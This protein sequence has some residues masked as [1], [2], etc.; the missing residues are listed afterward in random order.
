MYSLAAGLGN[1]EPISFPQQ[2]LVV[3]ATH[4]GWFRIA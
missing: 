3:I 2:Q 1:S 4:H